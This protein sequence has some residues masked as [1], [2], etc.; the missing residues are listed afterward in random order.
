MGGRGGVGTRLENGHQFGLLE[1]ELSRYSPAKYEYLEIV[2][3]FGGTVH[4][5][6][7]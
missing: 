5:E 2:L 4:F 7:I 1:S 3:L 6:S